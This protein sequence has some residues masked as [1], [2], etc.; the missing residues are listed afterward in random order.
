MHGTLGR[1]PHV[2]STWR[3]FWGKAVKF[4]VRSE[5]DTGG[6]GPQDRRPFLRYKGD[7]SDSPKIPS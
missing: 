5:R 6:I 3:I 1:T 2:G 7:Y 4:E